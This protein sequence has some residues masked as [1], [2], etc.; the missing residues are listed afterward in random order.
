MGRRGPSPP[1]GYPWHAGQQPSETVSFGRLVRARRRALDLTQEDLA[2][3]VGYSVITIRKV[4]SDERRPSKQLA[5]RLALSLNISADQKEM[6]A[7]LG[8]IGESE[9][10]SDVLQRMAGLVPSLDSGP[11]TNLPAPLTR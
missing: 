1:P 2:H 10:G 7:A 11:Q 6:F 9:P 4:E 5:E 3:K 8:R